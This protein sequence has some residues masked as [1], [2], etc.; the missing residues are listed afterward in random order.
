MTFQ[1]APPEV[2]GFGVMTSFLPLMRSGQSEMCFGLPLRVAMTTTELV[3]MPLYWPAA[4][5]L[6]APYWP[7]VQLASTRPALTTR[8]MSGASEN[9][10]TSAGRPATTARLWSPEAPYDSV[11]VTFLPSGVFLYASMIFLYAACGVE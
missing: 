7:C 4:V 3:T 8:S 11:K 1:R 9:S 6:A 5:L 2:N 10:T